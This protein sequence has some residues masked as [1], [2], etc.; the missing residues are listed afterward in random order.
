MKMNAISIFIIKSSCFQCQV[1][2]DSSIHKND[3]FSDEMNFEYLIKKQFVIHKKIELV[4]MKRMI[5]NQI[6]R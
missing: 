1:K 4:L 3:E 2:F 6:E 5:S